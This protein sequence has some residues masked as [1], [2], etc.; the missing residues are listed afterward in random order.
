[1]SKVDIKV[2]ILPV[3]FLQFEEAI[4]SDALKDH[5]KPFLRRSIKNFINYEMPAVDYGR[6]SILEEVFDLGI[7]SMTTYEMDGNRTSYFL[8]FTSSGGKKIT[9][10]SAELDLTSIHKLLE[11]SENIGAEAV[12]QHL[13]ELKKLHTPLPWENQWEYSRKFLAA[14]LLTV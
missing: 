1:M 2:L 9:E 10:A 3:F 14:K 13:N 11:M 5:D 7:P 4:H 6:A 12:I 8:Q